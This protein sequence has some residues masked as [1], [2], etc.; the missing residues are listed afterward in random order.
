MVIP[1][2]ALTPLGLLAAALSWAGTASAN[3]VAYSVSPYQSDARPQLRFPGWPGHRTPATRGR[4][5][6][7][8][9]GP[10][11]SFGPPPSAVPDP[12]PCCERRLLAEGG[13]GWLERGNA[14]LNADRVRR[15]WLRRTLART[16]E[17][18]MRPSCAI[19][20]ARR[21]TSSGSVA[22]PTPVPSRPALI[23]CCRPAP[24]LHIFAPSTDQ[25]AFPQRLLA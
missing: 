17:A 1:A 14:V 13:G 22:T 7:S 20:A 19:Q 3:P 25:S 9:V 18:R 6:L 8:R 16:K 21:A 5:Q 23:A 10:P 11:P 2:A 12:C 4:N 24:T 15:L